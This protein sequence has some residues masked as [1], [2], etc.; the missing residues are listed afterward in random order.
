MENTTEGTYCQTILIYPNI[1]LISKACSIEIRVIRFRL[2]RSANNENIHSGFIHALT[3]YRAVAF[4]IHCDRDN[5][6]IEFRVDGVL[7][8]IRVF[9]VSQRVLIY[10]C[11]QISVLILAVEFKCE[12]I[13]DIVDCQT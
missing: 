4:R 3:R 1:I 8:C 6:R 2:C 12:L 9:I 13:A 5:F 7:I 10:M 11:I